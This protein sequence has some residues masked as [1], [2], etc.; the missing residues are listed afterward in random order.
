[1]AFNIEFQ[2]NFQYRVI[3]LFN[4]QIFVNE[5]FY[6]SSCYVLFEFFVKC[7]LIN[8]QYGLLEK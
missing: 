7:Y 6:Q 2:F 1:M 4:I 3:P 8:P 5:F